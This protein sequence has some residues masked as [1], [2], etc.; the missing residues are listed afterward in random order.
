MFYEDKLTKKFGSQL[1]LFD[2]ILNNEEKKTELENPNWSNYIVMA[3]KMD[4][5]S[6]DEFKDKIMSPSIDISL[7]ERKLVGGQE[8]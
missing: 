5:T 4:K 6:P 7:L 2:S 3:K 8:E 1:S